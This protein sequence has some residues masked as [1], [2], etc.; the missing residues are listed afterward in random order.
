MEK[1][2]TIKGEEITIKFNMGVECAYED[3]TQRP[4][5]LA[6]FKDKKLLMALFHAA[7]IANNE[8]TEI[9][10]DYLLKDAT[11]EEITSLDNA[12]SE[13]MSDWLHIPAVI[14]K[15]EPK[16]EESDEQPKN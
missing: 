15:D 3:I 8:E 7:I 2:I 1:K 10:F 12:V 16:L 5:N 6:D 9:T 13:T 11:S 4:F 14:K